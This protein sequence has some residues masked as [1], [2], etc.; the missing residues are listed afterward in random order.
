MKLFDVFTIRFS[1]MTCRVVCRAILLLSYFQI[2]AQDPVKYPEA[3]KG[4]E[5]DT[6]HGVVI[7]D[8]Y[9]WMEKTDSPE[10]EQWLKTQKKLQNEY[11]GYR[12][13]V[14]LDN[15]KD[16]YN[17]Q[18]QNLEKQ[19]KY[20]FSIAIVNANESAKL[21]Y[22]K[23]EN[24]A[25]LLLF[26]P[27]DLKS[28]KHN[29]LTSYLLSDDGKTL[30]LLLTEDGSDWR[31]IRFL[32]MDSKKLLPDIINFV[33]YSSI[34]WYKQGLYYMKYDVTDTHESQ[35]GLIKGRELK[36]HRLGT[37]TTKDLSVFK[38]AAVK[39]FFHCELSSDGKY[40]VTAHSEHRAKA[41][42]YVVSLSP[43]ND[44]IAFK[45]HDFI[46]APSTSSD[47][48]FSVLGELNG[49]MLVCSNNLAPNG[50][51]Y[52]YDPASV[53]QGYVFVPPLTQKLEYANIFDRKI[54]LLYKDD[55]QSF[56][57][58]L[59]STGKQL[60][61]WKLPEG[62]AFSGMT[63]DFNDSLV[64]YSFRSFFHPPSYYKLNLET[65]KNE[66]RS[67]TYT[68]FAIKDLCTETVY[69]Y[70]KDSTRIP[71]YLTHKKNIK[72]DGSNPTLLHGY[73]GFGIPVTPFF[74]VANYIFINNGGILATPCLRGGGD[75]PGWYE[76]G[77][78]LKK[79]NTFDDFIAAAEYL[80]EKKYTS[81]ALLAANGASN[82][83]LVVAACLIQRP[84]LF[85]VV[86][87]ESGI[88]DMIREHIYNIGYIYNSEYGNVQDSAGFFSI[89]KYSPLHNIKK[90]VN[91]PA[92]LLVASENDDRVNPFHS[93]KFLAKLQAEA[94]SANPYVLYLQKNAG[95]NGSSVYDEY[96]QEEAYIYAFIFKYLGMSR[97]LK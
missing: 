29:E 85:R 84:D 40:I 23:T 41:Y 63:G 42:R 39:N 19:G 10:V 82:G 65:L 47:L 30:A 96:K 54:V 69:Y 67:K 58:V 4:N 81:P 60:K 97:N 3:R 45:K 16:S 2:S 13:N 28:D 26:D 95:H 20:F 71:M 52:A 24:G 15:L 44:S 73:G 21:Y 59:D 27:F 49:K 62:F 33:K 22:R 5:Q 34:F 56:G 70:S 88:Y 6:L 14:L 17:I 11:G 1:R 8:P 37:A 48:Y 80:I 77:K 74:S 36:Y 35:N 83:G 75:F 50:A 89:L 43:V 91:Y 51:I 57:V 87:A 90:G 32:D 25:E 76:Q 78:G 86:V 7:Q 79:Q 68:Q 93:Y 38:P 46:I 92:T 55:K 31:T 72:L 12:Y 18:Y 64:Y 9:R 61:A 66:T 53:N 94:G